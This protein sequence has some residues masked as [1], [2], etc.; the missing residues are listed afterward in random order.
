MF[1]SSATRV[2]PGAILELKLK[3]FLGDY[4]I[5]IIKTIRILMLV[6]MTIIITPLNI[7]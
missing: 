1:C 2:S 4:T 3:C 6:N 5:I 7:L